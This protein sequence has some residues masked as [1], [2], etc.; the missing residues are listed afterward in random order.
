MGM[1]LLIVCLDC[2]S[3]AGVIL[4]AYASNYD[5]TVLESKSRDCCGIGC[6]ILLV[7]FDDP[8][9]GGMRL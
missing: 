6:W 4:A 7:P 5:T 9:S 2:V 3:C 8:T 1:M